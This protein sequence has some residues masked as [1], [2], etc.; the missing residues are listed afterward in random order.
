LILRRDAHAL[1][2]GAFSEVGKPRILLS[3]YAAMV[4]LAFSF[5][6]FPGEFHSITNGGE[7]AQTQH[8]VV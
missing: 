5:P 8:R 7:Q 6:D 4:F 2:F 1:N 3:E